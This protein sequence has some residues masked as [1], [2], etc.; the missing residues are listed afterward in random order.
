M[1]IS[2]SPRDTLLEGPWYRVAGERTSTFPRLLPERGA[3]SIRRSSPERSDLIPEVRPVVIRSLH[4][5]R[6]AFQSSCRD[7]SH[8]A[9]SSVTDRDGCSAVLARRQGVHDRPERPEERARRRSWNECERR[10]SRSENPKRCIRRSG[11]GLLYAEFG[12]RD[13]RLFAS[14]AVSDESHGWTERKPID[15]SRVWND[16]WKPRRHPRLSSLDARSLT[17]SAFGHV[18]RFTPRSVL[19][20]SPFHV[21]GSGP[22]SGSFAYSVVSSGPI[23]RS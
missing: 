11:S 17:E 20:K 3:G 5:E 19:R 6:G 7:Q 1:R 16:R 15:G 18:A 4:E 12:E 9:V 13:L 22:L 2:T 21:V 8:S 14:V 23:R 10:T